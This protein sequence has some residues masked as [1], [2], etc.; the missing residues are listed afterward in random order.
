[1]THKMWIPTHLSGKCDDILPL[2]TNLCDALASKE[3]GFEFMVQGYL[4]HLLGIIINQQIYEKE[5]VDC[6]HEPK[7]FLSLFS[8]CN[9][10]YTN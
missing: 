1:M 8:Q 3:L 10:S 9:K 5:E 6:R 7:I 2:V 4:Y